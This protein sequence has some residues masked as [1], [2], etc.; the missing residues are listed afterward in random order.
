MKTIALKERTYQML[1]DLKEKNSAN[2]FDKLLF[3]LI[4]KERDIPSSMFGSLKGKTKSFTRKERAK[5]W[6]DKYRE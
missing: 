6:K 3:G 5:I 2:S 1:E 4:T